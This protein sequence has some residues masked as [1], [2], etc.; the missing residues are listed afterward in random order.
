MI[1][2]GENMLLLCAK[3]NEKGVE[4]SVRLTRRIAQEVM[5]RNV[6]VRCKDA[7]IDYYQDV[8]V[9]SSSCHIGNNKM[10]FRRHTYQYL[11]NG[12]TGAI[13]VWKADS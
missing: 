4:K 10:H 2:T 7:F 11:C 6:P 12:E 9:C 5:A 3:P 1:N 8:I 13:L